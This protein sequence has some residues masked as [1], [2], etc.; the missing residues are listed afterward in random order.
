M[1]AVVGT[2][3]KVCDNLERLSF[4]SQ[5]TGL[6]GGGMEREEENPERRKLSEGSGGV[7]GPGLCVEAEPV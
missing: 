5:G 1:G 6:E 7:E 2:E 3:D 4:P